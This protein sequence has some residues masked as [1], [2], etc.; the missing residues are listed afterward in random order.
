MQHFNKIYLAD[1]FHCTGCGACA[2]SCVANAII[3]VR[4]NEGFL[5]PKINVDKCRACGLCQKRCPELKPLQRLDYTNQQVYA[6]ISKKDRTKSSSGGAFSVFARWILSKNGVVVGASINDKMYVKHI[7]VDNIEGLNSLRGSK[8]VQSDLN[9]T[10]SKVRTYLKNNR[11]VLFSGTGCQVAGLYAFLGGKRYEGLLFTLDL[12]CHGAP[13]QGVFDSY[14]SKLQKKLALTGK[15]IEG[16]RFRKLDSWDYR[17][18]IKFS[19]SKWRLL[20][21]SENAYMDAFFKGITFRESCFNCQ[22]CNTQRIGTFT[23]ADFWGIGRHGSKFSKNVSSGVSL[24]IDNLGVLN[25]IK[26]ELDKYAYIEKRT[27]SEAIVEQSNL[28][29]PMERLKERDFAIK[30]MM[31]ERIS[32]EDF[33]K[34]YGFPYKPSFKWWVGTQIKNLIYALN[35]YNVYKTIIYKM[36]K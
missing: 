23:I 5:Q 33:S 10:Y 26:A 20:S 30:S 15:N 13:S 36:G 31:D 1:K 25:E 21:L 19:E 17:P 9:D 32:L 7:V 29:Y 12:I 35:L 34:Q 22:Y 27:M 24:V 2:S 18:A 11:M 16:F 8:Y 4:D 6:F 14:L 3:M 28:K